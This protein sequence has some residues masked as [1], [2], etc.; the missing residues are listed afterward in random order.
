MSEHTPLIFLMPSNAVKDEEAD[1]EV[2][3]DH[4]MHRGNQS[5][6]DHVV[7]TKQGHEMRKD[8]DNTVKHSNGM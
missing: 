6:S 4:V 1:H 5:D 3:S 2:M 8:V 7:Q